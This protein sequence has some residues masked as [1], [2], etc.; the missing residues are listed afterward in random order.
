MPVLWSR[1]TSKT[2]L[3]SGLGAC[4]LAVLL[5]FT[6]SYG[7]DGYCR[8][9]SSSRCSEAVKGTYDL[10]IWLSGRILLAGIALLAIGLIMFITTQKATRT[11]ES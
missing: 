2:G 5:F 1:K 8:G 7:L 6:G 10:M 11:G 4:I 3:I 9:L